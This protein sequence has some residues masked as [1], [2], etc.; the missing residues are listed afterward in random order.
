MEAT[1]HGGGTALDRALEASIDGIRSE[2]PGCCERIHLNNAGAGLMPVPVVQAITDHL[3]LESR[4]GGYEAAAEREDEIADARANLGRL[5][6]APTHNIAFAENATGA[7]VKALSSVDF[8]PGDVLLTTRN[9]YVS[10]QIQ[11]LSLQERFGIRVVRAPEHPEGGIDPHQAEELIH[12]LRPKLVAVTHVPTSSGLV[13]RVAEVGALCRAKGVTYLVDACQ[14]VGQMPVSVDDLQCDFLSATARKFLRGPRGAGFLYVSDRVLD[15]GMEPMYLD[16]RGADWIDA[17]VYQPV[18]DARRFENWEFAYALIL[19][20]G[21]AARYA[22]DI[23]LEPIRNRAWRLAAHLRAQL[24][25]IDGV[26]VLD[27]GDQLCAIVTITVEGWSADALALAL[28]AR[29]VNTSVLTTVDAV[30]DF[31]DKEAEEALRISPHYYNT[32]EEVA[33]LVR[34]IEA[35]LTFRRSEQRSE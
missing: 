17:G 2:T 8:R 15:A 35:F 9:D 16:L 22:M 10:N 25:E 3:E 31:S 7:F 20:M 26:T 14:S 30:L 11:Y 12:K 29:D 24:N 19:G 27:R 23:G 21:E 34:L 5:L 18:P 28:R 1:D 32:D 33:E 4:I 13:Q 6:A